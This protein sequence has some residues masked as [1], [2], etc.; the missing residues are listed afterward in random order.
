MDNDSQGHK[1]E[2]VG[3]FVISEHHKQFLMT[4]IFLTRVILLLRLVGLCISALKE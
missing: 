3:L 4:I 2:S 1:R